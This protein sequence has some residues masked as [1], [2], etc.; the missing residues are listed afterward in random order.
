[1]YHGHAVAMKGMVYAGGGSSQGLDNIV[2]RYNVMSDLWDKLPPCPVTH[3]GMTKFDERIVV[4]GGKTLAQGISTS[5]YSYNEDDERWENT[6]EDMPTA[7]HSPTVFSF[8]SNLFVCG[9]K[10]VNG[11]STAVEVY[12]AQD[13]SWGKCCPL[14]FAC[15]SMT[16]TVIQ[17][18]GYLLGGFTQHTVTDKVF[19]APLQD[20]ALKSCSDGLPPPIQLWQRLSNI[21][22][23]CGSAAKMGGVLLSIGGYHTFRLGLPKV[24]VYSQLQSTWIKLSDLPHDACVGTAV[25][26]LPTDEL[27]VIGGATSNNEPR[28]TVIRGKIKY[29]FEY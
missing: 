29:V 20:L 21:P 11:I 18:I 24:Y 9:G 14:P 22:Q 25:A 6:I 17:G 13:S 4:V 16:A 10:D 8:R 28:D 3:F 12:Q 1:M 7:R 27:L 15:H 5:V 26:E 2:M 23:N 19:Y